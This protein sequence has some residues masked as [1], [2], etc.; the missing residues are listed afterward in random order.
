MKKNALALLL[1]ITLLSGVI[2]LYQLGVVPHGLSWDEA[3]VGYNGWSIWTI[4]RDEWLTVMP[5]SFKSF[6][7]YKSSMAIYMNGLSTLLF[8]LNAFAIRLPYALSGVASIAVFTGLALLAAHRKWWSTDSAIYGGFLFAILPWHVHFSRIGFESGVAL[9]CILVAAL[10]FFAGICS[11]SLPK[12][13]RSPRNQARFLQLAGVASALSLYAYHSA[14]IF[15]PVFI[16][17][18]VLIFRTHI[19]I[20][21]HRLYGFFIAFFIACVPLGL[22]TIFGSGAARSSVLLSFSPEHPLSIFVDFFRNVLL[23]LNPSYLLLGSTDTMRHG[24][25]V[26]GILLPGFLVLMLIGLSTPLLSGLKQWFSSSDSRKT[27]YS[28]A[29][30]WFIAGMLPGWLSQDAPHANRTLLALPSYL[31]FAMIGWSY[32]RSTMNDT[33]SRIQAMLRIILSVCITVDILW[34]AAYQFHYYTQYV[35]TAENDFQA[36]YQELFLYVDQLKSEQKLPSLTLVSNKY[37]Q[38]YIFALVYEKIDAI[39]YHQG[40]LNSYL[41]VDSVSDA[42][43]ARNDTLI[44]STVYD[45]LSVEADKIIYSAAGEPRFYIYQTPRQF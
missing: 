33:K 26:F 36:G 29:L 39:S 43:L 44:V 27:I 6:G 10:F 8:G 19:R 23:H 11:E 17:L 7:D 41:F 2:R 42:D 5:I 3:A 25:G 14:K 20:L 21:R 35:R 15:V 30:I 16:V 22:D 1:I 4:H 31:A 12:R 18:S 13:Y 38:A 40:A 37:G 9:L 45:P 28:L 24:D 34:F 32:L